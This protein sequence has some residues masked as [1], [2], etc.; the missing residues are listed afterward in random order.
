MDTYHLF[1]NLSPDADRIS[2]GGGGEG[3]CVFVHCQCEI[4]KIISS[5]EKSGLKGSRGDS[6]RHVL[7][8]VWKVWTTELAQWCGPSRQWNG[9]RYDLTGGGQDEVR[10]R[11]GNKHLEQFC[12]VREAG[13][14][15]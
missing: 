14:G 13:V 4:R 1:V 3:G 6:T 12:L 10:R 8:R 7:M 9:G 15:N 5:Q 2:P 11:T